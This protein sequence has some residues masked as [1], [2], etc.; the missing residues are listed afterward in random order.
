MSEPE[1]YAEYDRQDIHDALASESPF[2]PQ[3]GT[4]GLHGIIPIPDR[5]GDYVLIVTYG[6]QEGEHSFDE[7]ISTDGILRWQSQPRQKLT[8]PHIQRLIRHNDTLNS[9]YLFLRTTERVEGSVA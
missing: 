5:P 3:A 7:G 8:D 6:R 1:L 4:W 9:I 2:T